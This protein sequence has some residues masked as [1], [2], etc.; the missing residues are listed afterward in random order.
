L[1]SNAQEKFGVVYRDLEP[2][3]R[4]IVTESPT[5]SAELGLRRETAMERGAE[6]SAFFSALDRIDQE[7]DASMDTLVESLKNRTFTDSQGVEKYFEIESIARIKKEE[8]AESMGYEYTERETTN[9]NQKALEQYYSL[10]EIA[11][12]TGIFNSQLYS[13]MR[14][15]L[16][17]SLTPLQ[18]E[19]VR[20]NTN[21]R[22][23]PKELLSILPVGTTQRILDSIE[24]RQ[25]HYA[26]SIQR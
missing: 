25:N 16:E 6:S 10:P 12:E 26:Q 18:R 20:R 1:D 24:A 23:I 7:R 19:Y 15:M 3:Q 9:D 21:R 11:S 4:D 8:S 14:D 5:V 22:P 2:Y 17:N 13:R